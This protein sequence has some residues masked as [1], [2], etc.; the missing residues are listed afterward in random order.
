MPAPLRPSARFAG[1]YGLPLRAAIAAT[2]PVQFLQQGFYWGRHPVFLV[3]P[4][5][6][7]FER[8]ARGSV[9]Q[10]GPGEIPV[11]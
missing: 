5:W 1:R 2:T 10:N 8:E 3:R 4:E 11:L 9:N 7:I 6:D